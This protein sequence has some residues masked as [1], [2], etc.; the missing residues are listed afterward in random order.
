MDPIIQK[1]AILKRQIAKAED[2]LRL[3]KE[4]LEAAER[5]ESSAPL[6]L[7]LSHSESRKGAPKW[8]LSS[9]EYKRYGRQM[10]VPNV[11]IQGTKCHDINPAILPL[12]AAQQCSSVARLTLA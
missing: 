10:I 3:L 11:G 8:P 7:S 12:H 2:E 5:E 4:Q 6:D 9:E 1:T